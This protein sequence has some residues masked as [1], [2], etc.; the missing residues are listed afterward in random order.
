MN[1]SLRHRMVEEQI[2][3]RGIT[4]PEVLATMEEIPRH[5]FVP[6][7]YRDQAYDDTPL[8]I[9]HSQTI[10]Q[11]YIV[12]LMTSLLELTRENKVLEIGTGSGYQTAVLARLAGEVYSM[13]IIPEL[14]EKAQRTLRLLGYANVHV[15]IGDGYQ[16]W[17]EYGPFDAILVTAAPPLIPEP[18]VDQ[19][20][21][22]G[23]MVVPVGLYEQDL[24][25]LKKTSNG[26]K[27]RQVIPVRFVPMTGQA[28]KV[29]W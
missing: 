9:G 28:Q 11:P 3:A 6:E 12:G 8:S 20:T 21:V 17:P 7:E 5:L 22:G 4:D 1:Q 10:S 14:G 24:Q 26:L 15:R 19:L 2:K 13:E 27:T 25:A 29:L 16:G 23:R 18:L